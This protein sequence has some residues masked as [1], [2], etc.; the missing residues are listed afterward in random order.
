MHAM[1]CAL[2]LTAGSWRNTARRSTGQEESALAREEEP[3]QEEES[4][5]AREEEPAQEEESAL[6]REE[7]PA[8]EDSAQQDSTQQLLDRWLPAASTKHKQTDQDQ[9]ASEAF[10]FMGCDYKPS[11]SDLPRIE[12]GIKKFFTS[13][14]D[15]S[16]ALMIA[17]LWIRVL[18][19]R[20]ILS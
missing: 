13:V 9:G 15:G 8:Q 14:E 7:E 5:L 19:H 11:A 10:H 2:P 4:A 20:S 16:S 1:T 18:R 12:Y 6:A 17:A 3:A